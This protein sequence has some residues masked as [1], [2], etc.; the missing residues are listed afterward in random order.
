MAAFSSFNCPPEKGTIG[1]TDWLYGIDIS[2]NSIV[3]MYS[4]TGTYTW[5][6]G[7]T[8]VTTKL[9]VGSDCLSIGEKYEFCKVPVGDYH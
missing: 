7:K 2:V 6:E 5:D 9:M 4:N 8:I 1:Y 3:G